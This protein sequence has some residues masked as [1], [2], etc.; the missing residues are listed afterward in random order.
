M[1][2]SPPNTAGVRLYEAIFDANGRTRRVLLQAAKDRQ[3]I[4][5]ADN[6]QF[7]QLHVA[8]LFASA[9]TE[10]LHVLGVR[11]LATF[12]SLNVALQSQ[13]GPFYFFCVD[14]GVTLKIK[15]D[16]HG[17]GALVFESAFSQRR[18][19]QQLAQAA[20]ELRMAQR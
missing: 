11:F 3:A 14:K 2:T 17:E 19:P 10:K 8:P 5:L 1:Q 12:A 16:A 6:K 9:A 20:S 13:K 15:V 7:Q 18:A 4:D